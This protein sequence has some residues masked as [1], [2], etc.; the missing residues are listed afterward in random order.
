M[1][2]SVEKTSSTKYLKKNSAE[3]NGKLEKEKNRHPHNPWYLVH[4]QGSLT[5]ASQ[6]VRRLHENDDAFE[7]KEEKEENEKRNRREREE[8]ERKDREERQRKTK[9]RNM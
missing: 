4:D 6:A 1:K 2:K 5:L 8:K 9:G 3:K 7:K